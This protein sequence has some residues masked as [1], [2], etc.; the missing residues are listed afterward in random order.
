MYYRGHACMSGLDFMARTEWIPLDR[1]SQEAQLSTSYIAPS[2]DE[3]YTSGERTLL[4]SFVSA[5]MW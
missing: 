2:G 4:A 1:A 3:F 5:P